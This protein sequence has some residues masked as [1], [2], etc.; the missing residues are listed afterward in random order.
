MHSRAVGTRVND[1]R[2]EGPQLIEP[3]APIAPRLL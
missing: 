1:A 3:S 2:I